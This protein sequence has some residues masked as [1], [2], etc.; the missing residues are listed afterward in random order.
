[1]SKLDRLSTLLD[2]NNGFLKTSDAVAAGVSRTYFSK[3]V[4]DHHLE[5]VAHGLYM[6]QDA[7][8]DGM[9]VI[10]VRYPS[11]IFSHES[12]AFLLNIAER[13]P[14]QYSIT[15]KAGANATSLSREGVKIYK[16]RPDLFDE[17]L[18]QV[19]SPAGHTL[20]VY[21]SERTICD[22]V[23]SRR[24]IEI[25]DLQSAIKEYIRRKDK[26]VPLLMRYAKMFSI[27]KIIRQYLEVLL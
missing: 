13:E 6:A 23:R 1:M 18:T 22:L 20:R 17:G 21:N 12:A 27:E 4:R 8:A 26:N 9:Y 15:L 25:Q 7:W 5:C 10:Q 3:Y 14:V 24:S 16:I 11:A 2:K 19:Q